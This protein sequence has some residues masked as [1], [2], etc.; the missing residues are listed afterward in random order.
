MGIVLE[1]TLLVC[2]CLE[3]C[4]VKDVVRSFAKVGIHA[5]SDVRSWS[6]RLRAP[7]LLLSRGLGS[8]GNVLSSQSGSKNA[9]HGSSVGHL[10]HIQTYIR[11]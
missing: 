5:V 11:K 1:I 6:T 7:L 3:Q 9:L 2:A 4:S 10:A 8:F